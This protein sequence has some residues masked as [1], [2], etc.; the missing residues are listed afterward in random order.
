MPPKPNFSFDGCLEDLNGTQIVR[1]GGRSIP[2]S[3][4]KKAFDSW[5]DKEIR[6]LFENAEKVVGYI[7]AGAP[8]L[9]DAYCFGSFGGSSETHQALLIKIEPIKEESAEDLLRQLLD[10]VYINDDRTIEGRISHNHI[11]PI[12]DGKPFAEAITDA[13]N[14]FKRKK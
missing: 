12:D 13:R 9:G 2:N 10:A 7:P 5:Y 3:M 1:F 4:T 14:Y 6:P 8:K 11:S